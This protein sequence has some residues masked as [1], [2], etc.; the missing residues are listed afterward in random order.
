MRTRKNI[1]I[2]E[3]LIRKVENKIKGT[4]FTFSSYIVHLINN[5]LKGVAAAPSTKAVNSEVKTKI[6]LYGARKAKKPKEDNKGS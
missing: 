4:G 5:D 2:D 3:D 1:S 6:D